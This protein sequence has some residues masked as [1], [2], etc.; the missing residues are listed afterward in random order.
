MDSLAEVSSS[1]KFDGI[2]DSFTLEAR[3]NGTKPEVV[4]TIVQN[5]LDER[6]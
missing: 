2:G 4:L 1:T 3:M 5:D 6:F